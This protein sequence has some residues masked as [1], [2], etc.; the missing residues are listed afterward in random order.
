VKD[1]LAIGIMTASTLKERYM[2]CE[3][4]WMKDFNNTFLFGGE[5]NDCSL[6]RLHGVGEDYDSAFLK[7]QLG[8][9][10]MFGKNSACDW[11]SICGCDTIY[12]KKN[13]LKA[14]NKHDRNSDVLLGKTYNHYCEIENLTI[15]LF[16]GG[17]G[18]F[19]SNSLMNKIYNLIDDFNSHWNDLSASGGLPVSRAC[20]DVALAYMIKKYLNIDVT[21]LDGLFANPPEFYRSKNIP[22]YIEKRSLEYIGEPLSHHY[23][24]PCDMKNIYNKFGKSTVIKSKIRG[25]RR[26]N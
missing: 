1:N 17:A 19:L 11:Y 20:G 18:F 6:I 8:L 5:S 22:D 21:H 26:A 23:I 24:K 12:F 3:R 2:A 14:L 10:Y 9:K 4:T 15:K 25:T 13:I 16:S 7:Q